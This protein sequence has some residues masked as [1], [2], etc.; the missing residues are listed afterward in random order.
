MEFCCN[1]ELKDGRDAELMGVAKFNIETQVISWPRPR[2][3]GDFK[4]VLGFVFECL[5]RID[6]VGRR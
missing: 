5:Q 4:S 2:F 6:H 3:D 1:R